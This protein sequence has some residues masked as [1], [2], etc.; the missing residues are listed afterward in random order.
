MKKIAIFIVLCF[1]STVAMAQFGNL[2]DVVKN[3]DKGN[4][5][6]Q[7]SEGSNSSENMMSE[8]LVM[9]GMVEKAIAD[10][11]FLIRQDYQIEEKKSPG[12]RY[13]WGEESSFGYGVSF[14]VMLN[15]GFVTTPGV[16]Y[17]WDYDDERFPEY[18]K[19]YDP[20]LS[21][22]MTL[23]VGQK[24]WKNEGELK[25][26]EKDELRNNLLY[27]ENN[28][29]Q[30]DGFVPSTGHGKKDVLLVW[31]MQGPE[32]SLVAGYNSVEYR[33]EPLKVRVKK[34]NK[35]CELLSK[36][37]CVP[38]GALGGIVIEPICEQVGEIELALLGVVNLG[39]F[40]EMDGYDDDDDDD[41]E[42]S[43]FIIS[44]L[45]SN[46][47]DESN[48]ADAGTLKATDESAQGKKRN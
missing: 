40:E 20:V 34:N 12:T 30:G 4:N 36:N 22:T 28:D 16:L 8:P 38:T 3:E 29:W 43:P 17:P 44:L 39:V 33:V 25:F 14:M 32:D 23:K 7:P 41:D 6:P 19:N 37:I 15:K 2:R 47:S 46:I 5:S 18:E 1:F 31:L 21:K 42:R 10:G 11:F 13:N 27:V 48:N 24:E 35:G 45:P 9:I 26:E